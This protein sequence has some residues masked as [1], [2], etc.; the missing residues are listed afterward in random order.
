MRLSYL[1]LSELYR[2]TGVQSRDEDGRSSCDSRLSWTSGAGNIFYRPNHYLSVL[3]LIIGP[4]L[5]SEL[6]SFRLF[7]IFGCRLS[8]IARLFDTRVSSRR[9]SKAQFVYHPA[10]T[11]RAHSLCS[12]NQVKYVTDFPLGLQKSRQNTTNLRDNPS[13]A[14]SRNLPT[15]NQ[16]KM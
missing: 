11:H 13:F 4:V 15:F 16:E 5:T 8:L 2:I 9:G 14:F 6:F 10:F 3:G 7:L 1:L 12:L